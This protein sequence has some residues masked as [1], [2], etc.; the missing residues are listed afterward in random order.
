M[1][2]T[3]G[4]ELD[5]KLKSPLQFLCAQAAD[6]TKRCVRPAEIVGALINWASGASL[7]WIWMDHLPT[8]G[9]KC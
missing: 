1:S 5:E 6:H 9:E 3:I 8:E 7:P 2:K 4:I